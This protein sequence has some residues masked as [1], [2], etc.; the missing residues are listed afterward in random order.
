MRKSYLRV[1]NLLKLLQTKSHFLFGP[2]QTGKSWL[3]SHQLQEALVVD[4][5]RSETFLQLQGRPERLRQLVLPETKLVVI[6]EIQ[7]IPELLNEVHLLME[8]NRSTFL[9]TGSSARKLRRGGV[10]LLGGRA[11]TLNLYPLVSCELDEDFDLLKALSHGTI[12]TH[13]LSDEVDQ[14]L[15][16]YQENYL[17]LE[18]A[19]EGATRN[20]AAFS[21]FLEVAALCNSHILNYSKIANDAQV[22]PTTVQEYF[23][24][25]RDTLIGR[26]LP[27]WK[28]SKRRKPSKRSKFYFFDVG[29]VRAIQN[30]PKPTWS[31]AEIG[32]Y[33]ETYIFH[34][35]SAFT[36]YNNKSSLAYWR[37]ERGDEVDFILNGRIAIEV[38]S[39]SSIARRDLKGLRAL[40]EEKAHERYLVV[41]REP[42]RRV[43]A[44][45]E[46][47][48]VGSFLHALWKGEFA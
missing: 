7:R 43:E 4:L 47:W 29:V 18:I 22:P 30:R 41:C 15:S 3:V 34:E 6:D 45:I 40:R 13:Y 17:Q 21:R 48:P 23:Q 35:L 1:V 16:A 46:V 25:L 37:S 44:E 2:R 27:T 5:L 26:D 8:Q 12:P 19:S 33:L 39:S 28:D 10:N 42:L 24:I 20:L 11:R 31:S 9:L 38:K 32:E 36:E 14:D